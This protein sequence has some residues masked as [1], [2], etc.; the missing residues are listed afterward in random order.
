MHASLCMTASVPLITEPPVTVME[1]ITAHFKAQ[2]SNGDHFPVRLRDDYG[3]W[4]RGS[5]MT[6]H[7]FDMK[8]E[9]IAEWSIPTTALAC[10]LCE[11]G[12]ELYL[13]NSS[14]C[15][16]TFL[17]ASAKNLVITHATTKPLIWL[18][19]FEAIVSMQIY[20]GPSTADGDDYGWRPLRNWRRMVKDVSEQL[21]RRRLL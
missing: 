14:R 4:K 19:R 15:H 3:L 9:E 5:P 12:A 13:V 16:F 18:A 8:G 11:E 6:V 1:P 20:I 7:V 21:Y 17:E 2:S 10:I